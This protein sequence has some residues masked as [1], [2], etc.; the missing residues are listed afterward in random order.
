V[1]LATLT[2]AYLA[3]VAPYE[4]RHDMRLAV[5][6]LLLAYVVLVLLEWQDRGALV[7]L[8]A[9]YPMGF[10]LLTRTGAIVAT[11]V[12]T[13]AFSLV[14]IALDGWSADAWL[15]NGL[16]AVGYIAFA[17]V[18]G[19]FIDG[20]IRE[21]RRNR[22]LVDE[23]RATQAELSRAERESGA[24]AERERMAR[25]IHDT[26]AQD[27]TSIVMLAQAG[28]SAAASGDE[29]TSGRRFVEIETT[30]REAL[31]EARALVGALTPPALDGAGLSAAV[32]RLVERFAAETGTLTTV[33]VLGDPRPLAATSDVA[34][35]R[36]T[37]EALANVRKHSGATHIS[38]VLTYDEDGATVS[39]SDDGT[40]F[41]P[42]A[43]RQG[44]GLDGLAS[45]VE[46]VGGIAEVT[47]SVGAGTQVRVR[48]P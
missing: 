1:G 41:D 29:A 17:L 40:G 39:V 4:R 35:L 26:L 13:V 5:A 19:L 45:R 46:A 36:A 7:L 14:L 3:V 20:L 31:A 27:F 6:F 8:F 24:L 2:V 12:L 42:A 34:A 30:A 32:T 28:A 43:P 48:V 38:V 15:W 33:E 44:Y 21:S 9:L 10:V 16:A 37:Q 25:E 23:L 22:G 47:S 18:M 11:V